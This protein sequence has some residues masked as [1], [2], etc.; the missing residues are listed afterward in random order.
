M[1]DQILTSVKLLQNLIKGEHTKLNY[2]LNYKLM[3]KL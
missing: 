2:K 1:F 3:I